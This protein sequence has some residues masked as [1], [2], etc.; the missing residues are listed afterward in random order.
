MT[1]H[2]RAEIHNIRTRLADTR[3]MGKTGHAETMHV[4][5]DMQASAWKTRESADD[6]LFV[7]N[8]A[9]SSYFVN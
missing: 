6:S 1:S 3:E 5:N 4:F 8:P 7:E 2:A 9:D